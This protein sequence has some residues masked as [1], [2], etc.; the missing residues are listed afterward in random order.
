MVRSGRILI[1]DDQ[2]K[3]RRQLVATLERSNFRAE[4]V[5]NVNEALERLN[6]AMY[7][8][9]VLDIRLKADDPNN[10]D[11]IGLLKELNRPGLKEATKVIMLSGYGTLDQMR[12]AFRDYEVADF[13][14]KDN[15][16]PQIFLESVQQV[17]TQ[18]VKINLELDI[19]W[20]MRSPVEQIVSNLEVNGKHV[21]HDSSLQKQLVEELE[22][23][24]CRLFYK[25][26]TIL[27]RSLTQGWSGTGVLLI[28]PFFRDR[29][30]GQGVIVKFGDVN[31]I[32]KEYRNFQQYVEG[33]ISG[34]R[35][36]TVL[37]QRYTPHLGGI[38]YSFLGVNG[39]L[40]DFA[41]F[42]H[43]IDDTSKFI[44]V[45]KHLFL[46]TCGNWYENRER[47][48]PLDLAENYQRIFNYSPKQL[49]QILTDRL[50][51][52]YVQEKLTFTSLNGTRRFTNPLLTAA[53]PS[54]M[55]FTSTCIM[56]GDFNPHNLF[57]DQ[58][59]WTWLIDFQA[60]EP[61]HI[62]HDIATL[63]SAI[64]FQLLTAQEATLEERLQ[65]EEVLCSAERFS[66]VKQ[67]AVGFKTDNQALAKA[68]TT[69]IQLRTLAGD[70]VAHN[71]HDDI[72]E[73]Y[74]ALFY[75]ALNTLRFSLLER[76]QHEH[77]LLCA[78][79]LADKLNPDR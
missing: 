78:S 66:Q 22:D 47:L 33:L 23:L 8:I 42:Y 45:L 3:W 50:P 49:E 10:V 72:S 58:V 26:K 28:Q 59:G 55:R 32:R 65:M 63:D 48:Q 69:V 6:N 71:Q 68:Y 54:L 51:S 11:G 16:S 34:G 70:L 29:G 36:T 18:K 13:L 31:K 14:E 15:F 67:L 35:S 39:E 46:D 61:G 77:A 44:D 56:H 5:K 2:Q 60:T 52:V 7:H 43:T 24:F 73:Y 75:N 57:V 12:R 79:L 27:V 20:Q 30:R 40:V 37:D 17:F 41:D 4:A 62:L 74:I 53:K 25:A 9:V 19:Q 1:V 76:V 21:G 38:I 64:R